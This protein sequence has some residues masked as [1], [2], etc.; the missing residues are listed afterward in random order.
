[1]NRKTFAI[2]FSIFI[3]YFVEVASQLLPGSYEELVEKKRGSAVIIYHGKILSKT[4][5]SRNFL[6]LDAFVERRV[7][8]DDANFFVCL[9]DGDW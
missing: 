2:S 4:P 9:C 8:E 5:H 3:K 6:L 1:M 7:G